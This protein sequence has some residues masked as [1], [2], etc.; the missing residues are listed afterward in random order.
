M[1]RSVEE[2]SLVIGHWWLH[3]C[4]D[5]WLHEMLGS[6]GD[7]EMGYCEGW[8]RETGPGTVSQDVLPVFPSSLLCL[9]KVANFCFRQLIFLKK[10][11][12]Y[13]F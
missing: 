11:K 5:A 10:V 6:W 12:N 13:R 3:G 4:M 8:R 2:R 9:K 1:G 7:G